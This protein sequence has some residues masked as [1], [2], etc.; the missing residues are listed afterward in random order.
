MSKSTDVARV[1]IFIRTLCDL[2][3]D[4]TM[5]SQQQLLLLC[6]YVHGPTNQQDVEN[7]TGVKKASNSRNIAKLGA[8]EK[9]L[10]APGPGYVTSEEDLLDRRQKKVRLTQKGQALMDQ[11]WDKSFGSKS[12]KPVEV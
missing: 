12:F 10:E 4:D 1:Q 3:Q 6:L 5:P 7:F 11:C 2:T 8:G 9:P